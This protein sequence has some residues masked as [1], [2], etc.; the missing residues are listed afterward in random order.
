MITEAHIVDAVIASCAEIIEMMLPMALSDKMQQ[1]PLPLSHNLKDYNDEIIVSIGLTGDY[2]GT[3]SLYLSLELSLKMASWMMEEDYQEFNSEVSE[4]V[5][6]VLNMISGGVKNRLSTEEHDVFDISLPITISGRD[7]H[8]F[9]GKDK[10]PVIIPIDTD[11]GAFVVS[12]V[13]EK[14]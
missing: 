3:M 12:L 14:K 6:E 7:K 8:I 4:S 11:K 5:G 2:S 9:H 13:L 1:R 10:T